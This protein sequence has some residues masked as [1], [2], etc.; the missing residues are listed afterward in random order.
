MRARAERGEPGEKLLV[1]ELEERC[2]HLGRAVRELVEELEQPRPQ[3]PAQE[4]ADPL[5][6]VGADVLLERL[7]RRDAARRVGVVLVE[8]AAH[9]LRDHEAAVEVAAVGRARRVADRAPRAPVARHVLARGVGVVEDRDDAVLDVVVASGAVVGPAEGAEGPGVGGL[10]K[11]LLVRLEAGRRVIVEPRGGDVAVLGALAV[12]LDRES[13]QRGVEVV[14][15]P[16]DERLVAVGVQLHPR[17]HPAPG[18]RKEETPRPTLAPSFV[19]S[20]RA[21][22]RVLR[23]VRSRG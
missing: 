16:D 12:A 17:S 13:A 14:R 3:L 22:P 8:V 4:E 6:H 2:V 1:R 10:V 9:E 7:E 5:L 15:R 23:S 21:A 20:Q 19:L 11:A 18:R